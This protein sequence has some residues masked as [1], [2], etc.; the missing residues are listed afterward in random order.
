MTLREMR[1]KT[2]KC[3]ANCD[4]RDTETGICVQQAC[5]AR[6]CGRDD[7]RPVE[8]CMWC[9]AEDCKQAPEHLRLTLNAR[10]G[11]KAI[12]EFERRRPLRD[13][14]NR[15]DSSSSVFRAG[16]T[17]SDAKSSA[18]NAATT[19]STG[20]LQSEKANGNKIEDMELDI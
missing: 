16:N 7:C 10:Y 15:R 11:P 1:E 4:T 13:V 19:N 12:S 5:N 9:D 2:I 18:Q 6:W 20:F 17:T 3:S 8:N 14:L